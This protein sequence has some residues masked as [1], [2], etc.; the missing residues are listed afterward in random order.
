M[1][2]REHVMPLILEACPSFR[3][4]W[5]SDLDD[6]DRELTY[7]CLG[8][9]AGHL[10]DLHEQGRRDEFGAIAELVEKLHADGD[11]YVREAATIGLLEGVQNV[12]GNGGVDPEEFRPFLLP[13]SAKWWDQLNLFWSGEIPYVGATVQNKGAATESGNAADRQNQGPSTGRSHRRPW[14]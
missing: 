13:E 12:W 1:I 3:P 7:I 4:V 14:S 11:H 6:D 8:R 5:E 2:T 10:L 9:F